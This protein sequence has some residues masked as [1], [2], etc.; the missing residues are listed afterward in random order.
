MNGLLPSLALVR[1]IEASEIAFMTDRMLA[2]RDRPGNPEG[3]EIARF[4]NAACF[5]SKTMPW[6]AFNTVKGLTEADADAIDSIVAF[7]RERGRAVQFEAVPALASPI[8]LKKLTEAGF[9]PSGIHTSMYMEPERREARHEGPGSIQES[10]TGSGSGSISIEALREDQLELY[11]SIH[12]KGTGLPDAGIPSVAANN[13]VLY[14]R[15][16]WQFY[17][18]YADGVAAGAGV[19]FI[20]NDKASFTFAAV[21]PAY[22][23]RGLHRLLLDKRI[24]A[25]HRSGC[26]IAVSQCAYLSQSQRNMD[27]AG[28]KLGYVRTTWTRLDD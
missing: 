14:G 28:M 24:D 25:A 1:D 5:Y 18:A 20:Q 11:A 27:R 12:C 19:L 16:G 3:I 2:I 6:P 8:V 10:G 23:N 22:R 13:R 15:P 26:K 9:Y 4:G 17:L 21:L 7:Y